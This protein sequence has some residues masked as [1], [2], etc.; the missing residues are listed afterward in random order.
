MAIRNLLRW[1][2]FAGLLALSLTASCKDVCRANAVRV[3]VVATG[4]LQVREAT[5]RNDGPRV[6]QMLRYTG[7]PKGNPWCAAAVYTWL[8]EAGV[9]VPGGGRAYAW[10]PTWHPVARQV[11]TNARGVNSRFQGKGGTQPMPADVFGLHYKHL[12]RVGHVGLLF[13]DGGKY[14]I[15][16]EGNTNDAGSREGDG[17][18]SKRRRKDQITVISRWIC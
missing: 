9:E 3:L 16:I 11:W 5:G 13:S 1:V 4:D 8:V 17:V 14:W 7:L 12:G 10:S 15:T 18:Y 6:E 2:L